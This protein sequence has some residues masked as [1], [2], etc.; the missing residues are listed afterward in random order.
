ME[1][2]FVFD[3]G[4]VV[5]RGFSMWTDIVQT[6]GIQSGKMTNGFPQKGTE[7]WET[8]QDLQRGAFSSMEFLENIAKQ[9]GLEPPKE[10]YWK[11]FFAPTRD[12]DTDSL[13]VKLNENACRVV[14]GT[15]TLDVHYDYHIEHGD[16]RRF[17]A[18]YASHLMAQA[19]PDAA[20][21]EYILVEENAIRLQ[22]GKAPFA[23]EQMLFF[24]DLQDNI[25]AAL[26]LGI[27]AFL[28]T[29][30]TQAIQDIENATG[31]RMSR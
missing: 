27:Q 13:L 17:G 1:F 6:M 19:K 10:N 2:L 24:D 7:R 8:L 20:F 31:L 9:Q 16:Y 5:V 14:A 30:A 22:N 18:V 15:N 25:D 28:F 3:I 21:W 11:T 29:D 26:K 12:K 4:G 23:F